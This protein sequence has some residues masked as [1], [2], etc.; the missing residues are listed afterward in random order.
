[1]IE[2]KNAKKTYGEGPTRVEALAGVSMK[3]DPGAFSFIV[4][5][6]GSGKTTLLDILG[7]LMHPTSGEVYIDG[8]RLSDFDDYQLAL[9]RRDRIGFVF[10][11]FNLLPALTAIENVL[12]PVYPEGVTEES[13][14]KA[15]K[16]LMELGL[17]DRI[18]HRPA[19][20]SGGERQR[21]AVARALINDPVVVLADEPTG[22]LDSR[23]GNM[24]FAYMRNLNK[25]HGVTFVVVTHD[26][27]YITKD[28]HVFLIK[29]GKITKH[30][31][32]KILKG[33]GRKKR[34]RGIHASRTST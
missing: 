3:L 19:E 17:A 21:V 20:L 31:H 1:M 6:S 32:E 2:V 29:D 23:T 30:D 24:L 9:F 33:H 10:Q 26:T 4:G 7:A 5:P 25:E 16:L 13:R 18:N 22:N 34:P 27:E 14:Q 15:A 12:V 11:S 28:D 8:K